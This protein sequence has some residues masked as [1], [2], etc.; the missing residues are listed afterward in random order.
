MAWWH[1][2]LTSKRMEMN[3]A[4]DGY[5]IFENVKDNKHA[6]YPYKSAIHNGPLTTPGQQGN[7]RD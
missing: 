7:R 4:H 5:L 2:N 6:K 3:R 1:A